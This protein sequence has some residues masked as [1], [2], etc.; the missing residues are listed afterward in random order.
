MTEGFDALAEHLQ[1]FPPEKMAPLCGVEAETIRDI[2]RTFARAKAGMIF[3]GMGISPARPRHR[4]LALPDQPRADVRACR[5]AG[6]GAASAAR[7]EQRAGG[8]RRRADPDGAA[9]L[10]VG[11]QGRGARPV[12]GDLGRRGRPAAGADRRR[13]H[14]RR[15]RRRHSRH[16]R[17]G[18]EPGHVRPRRQ[19]CPRRAG[20]ARAP[21]RAGHLPDRDGDVR[22]RH[23]AGDRLGRE[24][25]H[26]HQH[27]PPGADGPAGA[28]ASGR[29]ARGLLDPGRAGEAAGPRLETTRTRARSSPR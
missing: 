9:G 3:W 22:R 8:V 21:R 24:D 13:D 17:P 16:V 20:E 23:P 4:Q 6:D 5:A 7:P 27:Q 12:Q 26:R 28:V 1:G 11:D 25:R 19:P 29:G 10:P 2:A 18:R 14:G 15:A